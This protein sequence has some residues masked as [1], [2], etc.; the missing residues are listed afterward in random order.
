MYYAEAPAAHRCVRLG[1]AVAASSCVPGLFEPLSLDGLYPGLTVRLV[2]GGVH[3]NQGTRALLDQ[4]CECLVVSDASGQMD[5]SANPPHGELGVLLR[6]NS[7]LQARVRVAQ[8]QELQAR[9]GFG[10]VK[11]CAFLHLRKK[12]ESRPVPAIG[13]QIATPRGPQVPLDSCTEYG[14]DEHLQRALSDIRTDL[15]SFTDREALTLMYSGYAMSRKYFGAM[16]ALSVPH[17]HPWRFK[18]IAQAAAGRDQPGLKFAELLRHI[19]TAERMAFK[20]WYLH[21]LLR[22]FG[23]VLIVAVLAAAVWG[24]RVLSRADPAT[25]PSLET[26]EAAGWILNVVVLGVLVGLIPVV[27]KLV[28]TAKRAMHPGSW[29][30]RILIGIVMAAGGSLIC[31]VHLWTFGRLFVHLGRVPRQGST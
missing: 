10:L 22:F 16:T 8:H 25:L 21:P 17:E 29:A 11:L 27:K 28:T 18:D 20:V 4:D 24:L 1:H 2:D 26:P 23:V 9:E 7:A 3:D 14:I 30:L 13:M 6:T 19:R 12:L 31:R 5:S 15:D